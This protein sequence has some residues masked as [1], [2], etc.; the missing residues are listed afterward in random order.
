MSR[1]EIVS[2][3]VD[4]RGYHNVV[5]TGSLSTS[6]QDHIAFTVTGTYCTRAD[7]ASLTYHISGGA[8]KYQGASGNGTI[9]VHATNLYQGF[10]AHRSEIWNGIITYPGQS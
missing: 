5:G 6:R 10:I 7:T 8:G 1:L 3:T 4:S 2:I 9:M